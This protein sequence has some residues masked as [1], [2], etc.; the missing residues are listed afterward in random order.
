[1]M[2]TQITFVLS[3]FRE[4]LLS[5]GHM[6]RQLTALLLA[7]F[8][9]KEQAFFSMFVLWVGLLSQPRAQFHHVSIVLEC[10]FEC[11]CDI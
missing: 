6:D 3:T 4:R 7:D 9:D 11:P 2:S 8:C 5:V 1:M 10:F